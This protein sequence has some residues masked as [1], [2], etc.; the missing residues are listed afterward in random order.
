MAEHL[1]LQHHSGIEPGL[2]TQVQLFLLRCFLFRNHVYVL[3]I[4]FWYLIPPHSQV[5]ALI[6]GERV[7]GLLCLIT[8]Y[9]EDAT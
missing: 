9:V 2:M 8:T 7:G 6:S 3:V 1:S 5:S 4:V